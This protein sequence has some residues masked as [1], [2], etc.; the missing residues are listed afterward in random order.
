MITFSVTA[1]QSLIGKTDEVK[2]KYE[3]TSLV[4]TANGQPNEDKAREALGYKEEGNAGF[5]LSVF[6]LMNA[7]LGSGILGLSYAMAQLGFAGFLYV[8]NYTFDKCLIRFFSIMCLSVAF[9]AY[10]AIHL[11]LQLC[12]KTGVK[13]Y[14]RLGYRAFGKKGKV[15]I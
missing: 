3:E 7:I 8:T 9:L 5:A 11:L 10:Y 14:E 12:E 15:S 1:S 2:A 4:D 6:N 13:S